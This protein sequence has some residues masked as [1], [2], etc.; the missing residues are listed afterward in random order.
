[1][2]S[3]AASSFFLVLE[4][5]DGAGKTEVTHRLAAVLRGTLGEDRV[6]LTYEPHDP[7]VAG[8]YIRQVLA[9]QFAISPRT[10]ALAYA[11]NRADHN[12]RVLNP[13]LDGADGRVAVCDRYYLS[14]LVYNSSPDLPI[15]KVMELNGGARAPDLTL[16]LDASEETCY[17]RMGARGG[18]RELFDDRLAEMRRRYAQGIAFLQARGE[19]VI[20]INADPGI[21]DVLNSIITVLNTH[22]PAWL[23]LEPLAS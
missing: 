18:S 23:R 16:F 17:R 22:S 13:F 3:P 5:L 12:E 6:L 9:K 7:S 20:T 1:M 11:L 10:L 19:S 8:D 15:D 14:S 4:G 21:S 2:T